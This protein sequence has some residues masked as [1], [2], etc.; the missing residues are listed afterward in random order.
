[1]RGL[2]LRFQGVGS[3]GDMNDIHFCEG[4]KNVLAMSALVN[5]DG[6]CEWGPQ[7]QSFTTTTVGT[8]YLVF[9]TV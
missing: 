2:P 1:M 4:G 8:I 9:V 5:Q 6:T 3:S 7:Q